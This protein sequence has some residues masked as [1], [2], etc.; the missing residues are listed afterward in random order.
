[1]IQAVIFNLDGILAPTHICHYKAWEYMAE[2]QGIPFDSAVYR[3]MAGM[4]RMESLRLLLKRAKR[5][6]SSGEMWALSARKNDLFNEFLSRLG[7]DAAI[8]GA[9]ETVTLLREMGIRT[10]V[11]SSSEN[12]VGI[13][14]KLKIEPLFDAVIDG[15][16]ITSGKPDPEVFV[17][18]A[19]K[20]CM[21]T[22]DCLVVE[23][24][25]AGIAAAQAAGMMVVVLD[26]VEAAEKGCPMRYQSLT[27]LRL[28]D[29][30][31]ADHGGEAQ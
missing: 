24:T 29:L 3:Q 31:K 9:V 26:E 23:N 14:R 20:L 11:A 30:L 8:P 22:G 18:A 25:Q 13:L 7:P 10:A 5:S 16:Q 2:E 19:R 27:D 12:T 21:P 6:Y 1:M 15:S 28:P 4:K 17:L